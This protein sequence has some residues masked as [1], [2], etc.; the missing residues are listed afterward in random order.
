MLNSEAHH[1]PAGRTFSP[2]HTKRFLSRFMHDDECGQDL[3]EYALIAALVAL[4]ALASVRSLA[5]SISSALGD[6]GARLT[7]AV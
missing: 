3:I 1:S 7:G 2:L 4:G 6:V 5:S